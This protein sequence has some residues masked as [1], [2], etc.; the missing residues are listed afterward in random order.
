[1]SS[2]V[3]SSSI[4]VSDKPNDIKTKINKYA[5][6]GGGQTIEEHRANGCDMSVDVPYQYLEFFL[7]DDEQLEDIRVRYGS[8]E[9]LSG[10]VKMTLVKVM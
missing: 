6:T 5:K 1:M 4:L 9:L 2:S 7:E 8:G 3:G 10:E